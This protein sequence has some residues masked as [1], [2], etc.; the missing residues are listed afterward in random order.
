MVSGF[1]RRDFI[2]LLCVWCVLGSHPAEARSLT[3]GGDGDETVVV[4]GWILKKS[5]LARV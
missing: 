3:S 5:D 1:S 4:D 2:K